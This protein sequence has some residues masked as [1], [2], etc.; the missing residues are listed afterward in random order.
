MDRLGQGGMGEVF[1]ACH[2]KLGRVVALKLIRKERLDNPAAVRRFHREAQA[3][4]G[5]STHPNIVHAYDAA[6]SRR[7]PLFPSWSTSEGTDL[8]AG[9]SSGTACLPVRIRSRA[10]TS[11]S[12]ALGLQHA[13]ERGLVHRDVKPANL[14]LTAKGEVVKV[15]DM[16]LARLERPRPLTTTPPPP[17]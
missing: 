1:K 5:C 2:P 4:R 6:E 10:T 13:H 15:L 12:A 14:L 3:A 11:A 17:R 9:G 7:R 8:A 16:G